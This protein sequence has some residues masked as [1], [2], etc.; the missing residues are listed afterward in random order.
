MTGAMK[1]LV[2]MLAAAWAGQLA[3][4]NIPL[5][6][7]NRVVVP[8]VEIAVGGVLLL[9]F[10]TRLASLVVLN[11]MVVA[12]YVHLAVDDPTLFP[13]QPAEPV[14]PVVVMILAA[15]LLVRGGGS[16]SLDLKMA[17]PTAV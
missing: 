1:F 11:I 9:G 15:Y 8:F 6:E 12:T 7:V 14:I 17:G 2:P 5:A 10:Y 4:A 13:L 3:A 16:G